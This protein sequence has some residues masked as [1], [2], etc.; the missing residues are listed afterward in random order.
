[1]N[2]KKPSLSKAAILG[3]IVSALGFFLFSSLGHP[4]LK[5]KEFS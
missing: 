1:M 3:I 2:A 4:T 5:V